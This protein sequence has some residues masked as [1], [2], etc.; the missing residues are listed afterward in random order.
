M[1]GK[2]R[3]ISGLNAYLAAE[4][5][6][7][8]IP[9]ADRDDTFLV[10]EIAEKEWVE[11]TTAQRR[12]LVDHELC[13]FVL[14]EDDDGNETVSVVGHDLEEFRAV[15]ERHGMWRPDVRAFTDVA[16]KQLRLDIPRG[17]PDVEGSDPDVEPDV[18]SDD[19]AALADGEAST[20]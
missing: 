20:R 13:H 4:F 6:D 9:P 17:Q 12:A 5:A 11:L 18:E 19:L 14:D 8:E 15:V 2:A 1:L 7:D 10:I 3:K 16:V